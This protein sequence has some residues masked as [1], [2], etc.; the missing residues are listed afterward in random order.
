MIHVVAG[1]VTAPDGRVLIAE[2][3]AGKNLAGHWE[4]PGGKLEAGETRA[5]GLARELQE[6]LGITLRDPRPL[7][8]VR[9]TYDFG[10]VLIDLWVVSRYSGEPRG[11]DGQR[12]RWCTLDELGAA[13]LFIADRPLVRAL[14]LPERLTCG[15]TEAYSVVEWVS[16]KDTPAIPGP[17]NDVPLKGE[18][19][20]GV[21]DA[22]R[23]ANRGAEF[24]VLQT[25]L[26]EH[27][28]SILCGTLT[29][30]VFAQGIELEVAWR[31]G[32]T[33]ISEL[34]S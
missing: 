28:L 12:L 1:A 34:E 7:M 22:V 10:E 23:A 33:G 17:E 29:V 11:L 3:P 31:Q 24:V 8:R 6:E 5:Q 18:L 21:A 26:S 4:F 13:E 19:C 14:R 16:L 9:H 27:E 15:Q 2:R 20:T 30:P 25:F 32:A